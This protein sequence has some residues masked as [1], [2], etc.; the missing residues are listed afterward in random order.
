MSPRMVDLASVVEA[1]SSPYEVTRYSAG[2]YV[3]GHYVAAG[4][5][6]LEVLGQVVPG[7]KELLREAEG[8]RVKETVQFTTTTELLTNEESAQADRVAIPGRGLFEVSDVEDWSA[9]AGF[10]TYTL[11][12][13]DAGE[14]DAG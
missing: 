9:A 5:S 6:T 10:Y 12:R 13:V 4:A 2:E 14:E 7:S 3:G 11:T 8:D 1:F